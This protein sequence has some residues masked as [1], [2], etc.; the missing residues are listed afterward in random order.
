MNQPLGEVLADIIAETGKSAVLAARN[1]RLAASPH[2]KTKEDRW[3]WFCEVTIPSTG[4][5]CIE[6]I[7]GKGE[8]PDEAATACY[9]KILAADRSTWNPN[10]D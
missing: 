8:T 10:A 1:M 4:Q 9:R 3:I 6:R 7:I 2:I 5:G